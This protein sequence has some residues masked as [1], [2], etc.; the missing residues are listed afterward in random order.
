MVNFAEMKEDAPFRLNP[1]VLQMLALVLMALAIPVTLVAL[2]VLKMSSKSGDSAVVSESPALRAALE[3][4][5]EETFPAPEALSDGRSIYILSAVGGDQ[6]SGKQ[7]EIERTA[8]ALKGGILPADPGKL[9]EQRILVQI[10]AENSA[11]FEST[12]LQGFLPS[13]TGRPVQ[14]SRIYEF[15]FPSP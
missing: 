10:P 4:A 2:G 14:G 3:Q 9:G 11:L 1:Q 5:A 12:A 13:R 15:I 8:R 7:A 6:A